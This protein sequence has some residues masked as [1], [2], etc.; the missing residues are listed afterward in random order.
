MTEHE[1]FLDIDGFCSYALKW[2]LIRPKT[3]H[4]DLGDIM[5]IRV[6]TS[7]TKLNRRDRQE[8]GYGY[9]GSWKVLLVTP[10]TKFDEVTKTLFCIYRNVD[11]DKVE[12]FRDHVDPTK[13]NLILVGYE[14]QVKKY[15]DRKFVLGS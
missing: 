12:E 14:K 13:F 3:H 11:P 6:K 2:F 1:V 15:A 8:R 7:E 5:H 10:L 9:V 4:Y